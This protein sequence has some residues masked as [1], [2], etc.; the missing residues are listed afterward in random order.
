MEELRDMIYMVRGKWVMVDRDVAK[1]YGYETKALNQ[2]VKRNQSRFPEHYCF[3]LTAEEYREITQRDLIEVRE[4][5]DKRFMA[6][7]PGGSWSQNVTMKQ[8]TARGQNIKY[9]PYVFSEQGIAMLAGLLKSDEAVTMSIRL[10][11]TFVEMR[12]FLAENGDTISRLAKVEYK[13]LEQGE[14]L[15]EILEVVRKGK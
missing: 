10:I 1:V 6:I 2:A 8:K 5:E 7:T 14:K 11:D 15:D 4:G 13:V 3:Q 12:N 9:L